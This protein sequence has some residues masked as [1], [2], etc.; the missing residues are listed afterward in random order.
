MHS[1]VRSLI[2]VVVC[3]VALPCPLSAEESGKYQVRTQVEG[4]AV[5]VWV[6][7]LDPGW[8]ERERVHLSHDGPRKAF[9]KYLNKISAR[10]ITMAP[11]VQD[12]YTHTYGYFIVLKPLPPQVITPEK[13]P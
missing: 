13:A 10:V 3:L 2:L 11:L 8:N 6:V 9:L 5:Y 4:N 1:I 12:N 7:N